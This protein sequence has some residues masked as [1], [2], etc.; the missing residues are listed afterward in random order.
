[1]SLQNRIYQSQ[2]AGLSESL[3]T[4]P[5]P[6]TSPEPPKSPVPDPNKPTDGVF[7]DGERW[8]FIPGLNQWMVIPPD[9]GQ[10]RLV[11]LSPWDPRY[12][13]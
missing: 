9:G 11:P 5:P 3:P 1:M 6:T 8:I 7:P 13:L 12:K 4:P 2:I 10:P